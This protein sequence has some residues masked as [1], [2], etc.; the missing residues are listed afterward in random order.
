MPPTIENCSWNSL[1]ATLL[2]RNSYMMEK[3][4]SSSTVVKV[5][6]WTNNWL[7]SPLIVMVSS[8]LNLES[9]LESRVSDFLTDIGWSLPLDFL[10]RFLAMPDIIEALMCLD[11]PDILYQIGS[12]DG[13]VDVTLE[14]AS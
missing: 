13:V 7:D 6:F 4:P 9:L 3:K 5:K 10:H 1:P 8:P 11:S 2:H 12:L 14:G